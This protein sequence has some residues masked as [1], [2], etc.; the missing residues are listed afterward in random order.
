[1]GFLSN[2]DKAHKNSGRYT[3]RLP[4]AVCY[5]PIS[6]RYSDMI[7][8]RR[9]STYVHCA[10]RYRIS[11]RIKDSCH[12]IQVIQTPFTRIQ[13]I[14]ISPSAVQIVPSSVHPGMSTCCRS[15][16]S[17]VKPTPPGSMTSK[18]HIPSRNSPENICCS[19]VHRCPPAPAGHPAIFICY[20][21]LH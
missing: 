19:F 1:M 7:A 16:F 2:L 21:N 13:P 3:F 18:Q 6:A 5:L 4:A 20:V 10:L 17:A 9:H 12:R 14:A 8:I 11:T 15:H